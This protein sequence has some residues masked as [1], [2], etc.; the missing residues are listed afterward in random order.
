MPSTSAAGEASTLPLGDC[1]ASTPN[2]MGTVTQTGKH[3]LN[4][5]IAFTCVILLTV[6]Y[7]QINQLNN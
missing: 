5:L 7:N 1:S 2:A 6:Q 4:Q 3:F